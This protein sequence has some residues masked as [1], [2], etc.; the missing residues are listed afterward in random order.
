MSARGQRSRFWGVG[1]LLAICVAAGGC[2][3]DSGRTTDGTPSV[4]GSSAAAAAPRDVLQASIPDKSSAAFQFKIDTG[5]MPITGVVDPA[6]RSYLFEARQADRELDF[7]MS[8]KVLVVDNRSWLKVAFSGADAVRLPKLPKAWMVLDAA[9]LKEPDFP[10]RFDGEVDMGNAAVI[11][12]SIV[13]VRQTAPGRFAGRIDLTREPEAEFAE[14]KVITALGEQAKA[15]PFTAAVDAQGRL[16]SAVITIPAVGK[17][18]ATRYA[19]TYGGYG[20]A[21][22]PAAPATGAQRKAPS[23]AYELLNS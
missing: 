1:A 17:A 14:A 13:D 9:K 12:S 18:K 21:R 16:T 11:V 4:A 7:T 20:S 3:G 6:R 8:L 22:V 23:F 2:G 10:A 15:V 5:D 19:V